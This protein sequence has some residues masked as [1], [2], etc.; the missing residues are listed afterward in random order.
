[1]RAVEMRGINKH[2]GALQALDGVNLSVEK[3]TIHGVVGENGAGKTTLMRVLYGGLRPDSGAIVIDGQATT[4]ASTS[5]AIK[6]GIGMVSQHYS[7]IPELT[8]LQNLM[9]G[10][11]AGL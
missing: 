6:H 4:F 3:G 2:F 10:A 1:M 9:L 7:V 8:N 5:D 11:E